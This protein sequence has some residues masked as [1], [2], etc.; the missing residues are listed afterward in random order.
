[1]IIGKSSHRF[2]KG[3][4]ESILPRLYSNV[5]IFAITQDTF[6]LNV[7]E[8]TWGHLEIIVGTLVDTNV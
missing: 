6:Y 5:S 4:D 8:M 7:K 1:M 3:L 2:P